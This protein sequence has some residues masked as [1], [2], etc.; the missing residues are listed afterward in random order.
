MLSPLSYGGL[1]AAPRL[2]RAAE[3]G[4][5]TSRFAKRGHEAD[6]YASVLLTRY[7]RPGGAGTGACARGGRR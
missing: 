4:K 3:R 2:P 7:S 6:E 5:G 1:P